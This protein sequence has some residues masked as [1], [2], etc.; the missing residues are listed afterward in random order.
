M[1][2]AIEL[3]QELVDALS[4][5]PLIL[6]PLGRVDVTVASLQSV[7]HS[8]LRLIIRHLIDTQA[9]LWDRLAIVHLHPK[10]QRISLEPSVRRLQSAAT[11]EQTALQ[12]LDRRLW[13]FE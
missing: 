4:T 1:M 7:I 8:L 3:T 10:R 2:H 13:E 6:V 12:I 9:E 5:G 11:H